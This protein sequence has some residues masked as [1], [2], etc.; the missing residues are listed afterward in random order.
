MI[1]SDEAKTKVSDDASI[2]HD[3][4]IP[5]K[6]EA[7][8]FLRERFLRAVTGVIGENYSTLDTE[9]FDYMVKINHINGEF[10]NRRSS[11]DERHAPSTCHAG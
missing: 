1:G 3:F 6:Q 2:E 8:T 11:S 7:R 10:L 5:E 9:L 4:S